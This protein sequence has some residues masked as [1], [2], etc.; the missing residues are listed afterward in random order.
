MKK[1]ISKIF[2]RGLVAMGFGPLIYGLV[3]LI[4]HLCNVDTSSNGLVMFKGIISTSLLAFLMASINLI[5][6][7]DRLSLGIKILIHGLVIYI[8]YLVIY[9][10]NDWIN[11]NFTTILIFS[12]IFII[13]YILVWIIIYIIDRNKINNL[14]NLIKNNKN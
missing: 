10:L 9:L 12:I 1:I 8:G 3:M 11:K 5:Y 4:L 13:G 14:N 2:L 6:E 7:N